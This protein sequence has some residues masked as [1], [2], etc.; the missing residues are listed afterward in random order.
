MNYASGALI[1]LDDNKLTSFDVGVFGP[2]IRGFISNK[3]TGNSIS[4]AKS[5]SITS[6][7]FRHTKILFSS[8]FLDDF[9]CGLNAGCG[10]EKWFVLNATELSPYVTGGTCQDDAPFSALT[11]VIC[12]CPPAN[13]ISPCQCDFVSST[14]TNL[15]LSC[16]AQSLGDAVMKEKLAKI[17]AD[18]YSVQAMD[19]SGN[20]LT[21]VPS[22]VASYP[23]LDTVSLASNQIGA[24]VSGDL[25]LTATLKSLDVSFNQISSI[26]VGALPGN[27]H[28][29]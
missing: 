5:N 7:Q 16:S 15:K 10:S 4:V 25:Q 14:S 17:P 24:L 3:Q 8:F 1:K 13:D 12:T 6:P 2:I 22:E 28:Y 27:F 19:L 18:S 23:L 29:F 11:A 20:N 21:A 9:D 26:A